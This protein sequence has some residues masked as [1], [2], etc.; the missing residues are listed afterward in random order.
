MGK[1]HKNV[2]TWRDS[3]ELNGI[4]TALEKSHSVPRVIIFSPAI[5]GVAFCH[6]APRLTYISSV[7]RR[8]TSSLVRHRVPLD[9]RKLK[10]NQTLSHTDIYPPKYI[11]FSITEVCFLLKKWLIQWH[12]ARANQEISLRSPRNFNVLKHT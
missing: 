3:L 7:T 4:D 11:C 5:T 8:E 6:V 10:Q 2:K 12:I 9:V 1:K